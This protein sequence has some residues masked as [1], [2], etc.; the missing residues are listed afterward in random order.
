[1]R[2]ACSFGAVQ[3]LGFEKGLERIAK[4]GYEGV[5]LTGNQFL[6]SDDGEPLPQCR[7][8]TA[9]EVQRSTP[10]FAA[11]RGRLDDTGVELLSMVFSYFWVGRFELE[12]MEDY[13]RLAAAA[14]APALKVAGVLI[15]NPQSDYWTSLDAAHKQ[16]D[17]VCGFAEK[18]RVRALIELHDGYL[19]ESASQ[20]RRFCEPFAPEHLGV[21]H[22]PE[23]MIRSGKE[24]WPHSFDILGAYLTY[25][26]WKNMGFRYNAETATWERCR[27][28]LAEG[29]VDWAAIVKTLHHRA[30]DGY[31]V[32]ENGF[33]NEL[34]VVEAD[35]AYMT[36]LR[37]AA[38]AV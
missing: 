26:H 25:L 5:E 20:A 9:S 27:T 19:H 38:R 14:G 37:D 22:D 12:A 15:G 4:A 31:L 28:P 8:L 33:L 6:A 3:S 32:N 13:F 11:A 35:L 1:M 23:N 29:L 7:P 17:V 18:H 10:N 24:H 30:F 34:S 16:M 36:G 2:F 21:I